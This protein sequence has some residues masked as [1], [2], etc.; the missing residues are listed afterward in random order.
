MEGHVA[1]A[2]RAANAL[3]DK[4]PISPRHV[5][6]AILAPNAPT[7]D[8]FR[9]LKRLLPGEIAPKDAIQAGT[10]TT[11]VRSRLSD[12]RS[13]SSPRPTPLPG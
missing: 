13:A 10:E 3:A 4:E 8:A 9:E 7:S 6:S 12:T 2:L 1:N 5:L 11:L